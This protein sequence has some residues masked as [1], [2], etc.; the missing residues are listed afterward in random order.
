MQNVQER[1]HAIAAAATRAVFVCVCVTAVVVVHILPQ[2]DMAAVAE[3]VQ[4]ALCQP[5]QRFTE[6]QCTIN[7]AK[8]GGRRVQRCRGRGRARVLQ[9]RK[10]THTQTASYLAHSHKTRQSRRLAEPRNHNAELH[11]GTATR[12]V[13]SAR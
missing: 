3:A 10:C 2:T 4:C 7:C 5:A 13:K 9:A 1:M 6:T 12:G 11:C 8:K